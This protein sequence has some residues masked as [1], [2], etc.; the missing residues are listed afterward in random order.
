MKKTMACY[1]CRSKMAYMF[2]KHGYRLFC[3][4]DCGLMQ[5]EFSE[6]YEDFVKRFYSKGYFT[7][8]PRYGAF[9]HYEEDKQCIQRNTRQVLRQILKFKQSGR[10]LDVGCA[11]GFFTEQARKAGFDAY[12]FD[13]SEY[14]V[15]RA[16]KRLDG[17]IKRGTIS[18][19]TY[20]PGSFDVITMFDVFEHL[21]DPV[22]DIK[23]L[24]TF[25]KDDGILVIA[26]GNTGSLA[27]KILRRHWTFFIPPQHLFFFNR[28]TMM[29]ALDRAG[30]APRKWFRVGKWLSLG[31]VTH[32]AHAAADY[33]FA[34]FFL[35][36]IERFNIRKFPVFLPMGDNMVV[37]AGKQT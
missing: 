7:G 1:L 28:T 5:T 33:P 3:C 34:G 36:L 17:R 18:S 30:F 32:L 4:P 27:A 35:D 19:V 8:D 9:A 26:T 6:A 37:I 22:A 12:G 10:L 24:G 2:T 29:T 14:A 25:L 21:S 23:R 31:Y 20:P 16:K 15:Q 13:P 11:M